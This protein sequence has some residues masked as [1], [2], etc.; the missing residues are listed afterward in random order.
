M[1]AFL[2][3]YA[4]SLEPLA[5]ILLQPFVKSSENVLADWRQGGGSV[6]RGQTD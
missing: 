3:S 1:V 6:R 5:G 4:L 2:D